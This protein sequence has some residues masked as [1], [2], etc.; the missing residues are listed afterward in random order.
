MNAD[1]KGN[2]RQMYIKKLSRST[3]RLLRLK[4]NCDDFPAHTMSP[5]KGCHEGE[6]KE[7][8]AITHLLART[9]NVLPGLVCSDA[10]LRLK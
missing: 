5:A 6:R 7:M 4:S 1:R 10:G 3:G 8:D 2:R 9:T